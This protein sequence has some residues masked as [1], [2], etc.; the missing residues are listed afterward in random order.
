[1]NEEKI[2]QCPECGEK[3]RIKTTTYLVGVTH[4][5]NTLLGN[6]TYIKM[7]MVES[8][9]PDLGVKVSDGIG[10]EDIFGGG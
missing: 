4:I 7:K 5:H 8:S 6:E 3:V 9:Q 2:Y 1:M 10:A